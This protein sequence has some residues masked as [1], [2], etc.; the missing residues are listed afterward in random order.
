MEVIFKGPAEHPVVVLT[1]DDFPSSGSDQPEAGTMALLDLLGE[2]DIPAT[3][4]AIGEQVSKHP[5][6]A[7]RAL[8]ASH[9]LGNHLWRDQWSVTLGRESFLQQLDDTTAAIREDL[10]AAGLSTSLRWFRPSGGWFHP[11]MLAWA[12][13]R[14]YRTVLGSIWPLDGLGTAPPE[15]AQRWF[16]ERFANPV[17]ITVVDDSQAVNPATRRTLEVVVPKLK[18]Q[19]FRFVTLSTLF[20]HRESEPQES[21]EGP[22]QS[23]AP[24]A[25]PQSTET[26]PMWRACSWRAT[27]R[28]VRRG[29]SRGFCTGRARRPKWSV[30]RG[31]LA[32]LRVPG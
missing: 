21:G 22:S 31:S 12:A 23:Q 5:G 13:S 28:A 16:V 25:Q 20:G 15:R 9:E 7:A 32:A 8:A 26:V 29:I 3:F 24:Q 6:L 18:Q 30:R 17:G 4:F 10:A 14:G 2:L 27:D 19:E 11:P 1:L